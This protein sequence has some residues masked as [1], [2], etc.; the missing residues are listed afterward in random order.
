M[1]ALFE[2]ISRTPRKRTHLHLGSTLVKLPAH[3]IPVGITTHE[4][5]IPPPPLPPHTVVVVVGVGIT[6]VDHLQGTAVITIVIVGTGM[7]A[8]MTVMIVAEAEATP[9]MTVVAT[10]A[11]PPLMTGPLHMNTDVVLT[12]KWMG[13]RLLYCF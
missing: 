2:W 12:G 1:V 8:I 3:V 4:A 7:T 10:T 5:L 6:T 11:L 13:P 9:P